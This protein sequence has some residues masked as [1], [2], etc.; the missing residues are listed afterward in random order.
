MVKL[1]VIYD[2]VVS[3]LD[4]G[5]SGKLTY[6]NVDHTLDVTSQCVAIAKEEGIED[7][8]ILLILQI[9]ALYHDSGFLYVYHHHEERG[10][11]LAREQLPDFGMNEKSIEEVCKLI[12]ATKVPQNPVSHLQQIICDADLDYLGRDDFFETGDRLRREL[13]EYKFIADHH[14]WEKRQLDFLR[15]HHYFTWASQKKRTPAK[16]EF[17][18]QLMQYQN[19]VK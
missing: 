15:S 2:H 17:I 10:C 9:A 6:H 13:L 14:D 11:E 18:K 12:M 3:M 16:M 1:T 5:L 4:T 19:K 7:K 8:D